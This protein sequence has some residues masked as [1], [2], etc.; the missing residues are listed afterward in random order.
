[1]FYDLKELKE[2]L[3]DQ[4]DCMESFLVDLYSANA[5]NQNERDIL[6]AEHQKE[7]YISLLEKI[8]V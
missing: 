2:Y 7:I 5:E 4:I 1:M 6:M 3:Q 8:G